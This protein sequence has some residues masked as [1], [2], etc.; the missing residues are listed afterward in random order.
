MKKVQ[1]FKVRVICFAPAGLGRALTHTWRRFGTLVDMLAWFGDWTNHLFSR[2]PL[3]RNDFLCFWFAWVIILFMWL[4]G[5]VRAGLVWH[6]ICRKTLH[7]LFSNFGTPCVLDNA[8]ISYFFFINELFLW[9]WGQGN[10]SSLGHTCSS[11]KCFFYFCLIILYNSI[12]YRNVTKN[13]YYS[14]TACV[15][16]N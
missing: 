11:R 13:S 8:E 6:R 1:N 2:E 5:I 16:Q 9:G 7:L 14:T 15:P 3:S 12:M 4:F 10:S